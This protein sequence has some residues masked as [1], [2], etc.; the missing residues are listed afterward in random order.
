MFLCYLGILLGMF[1]NVCL[2]FLDAVCAWE[3]YGYNSATCQTTQLYIQSLR[4]AQAIN[5]KA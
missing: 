5:L 2:S 3:K 1:L 4:L